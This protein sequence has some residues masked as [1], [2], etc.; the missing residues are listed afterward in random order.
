MN[1]FIF[2]MF[3]ITGCAATPK[4]IIGPD[5]TENLLIAEISIEDCYEK[6]REICKGQ[7]KII[8]STP[9]AYESSIMFRLLVKCAQ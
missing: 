6:A 2:V 4:K 1:K 3:I 8:D 9:P 5:G 7:Y